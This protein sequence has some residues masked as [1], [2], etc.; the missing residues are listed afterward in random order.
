[1]ALFRAL[2][3]LR[4]ADSR[5]F[6]DPYAHLFLQGYR[7]WLYGVARIP[8]GRWTAEKLLDRSIPGARAGGIARTKWIDDEASEALATAT[9]LVLLGAGFDTR[10][11]RLAAARR[12]KVFELDHPETSLVKQ[13]LL[14]DVASERVR[15]VVIDFNRQSIA[16]VLN[17]A[18][19]DHS[20]PACFIWEGVTNYLAPEAIDSVLRQVRQTANGNVLLFTYVDRAVLEEPERFYKARQLLARVNS[21][22]EPWTFGFNPGDLAAYLAERGFKLM[23]DSGVAEVWQATGRSPAATRGYEFYRVA[24]TRV[25]C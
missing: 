16:E 7:R 23:K 25:H 22:G 24:H 19:F 6:T 21:Y 1:M 2:E 9:Q 11:H 8:G 13:A 4:P 10:A 3:S 12:V 5:L 17:R 18:G 14:A 15:Y 20:Q